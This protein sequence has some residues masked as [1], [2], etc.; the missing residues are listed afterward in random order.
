VPQRPLRPDEVQAVV[1]T[2]LV[3]V[4]ARRLAAVPIAQSAQA[5]V[6]AALV[7]PL[8]LGLLF[9]TIAL[10]RVVQAQTA[11]VAVAHEVARAGALASNPVDAADRMRR[12][13]DLVAP[14][15]GLDPHAVV[16]ESDVSMFARDGGRVVATVRYTVVLGDLPI[17]GW[18]PAPAVR[19]EHVE[20]LD[21]FRSGLGALD[22]S[23]P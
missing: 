14:G 6:E 1:E 5:M 16:L 11:V 21:P 10:S 18:I 4:Q 15:F 12:R 9:G 17:A 23:V 7:L 13:V 2:L 20:W 8:V 19:A 22:G 3:E